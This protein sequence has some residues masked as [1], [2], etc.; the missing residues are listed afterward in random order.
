MAGELAWLL[1]VGTN[2]P[3]SAA[4]AWHTLSSLHLKMAWCT[5]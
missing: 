5:V 1:R 4:N 2:F 3:L